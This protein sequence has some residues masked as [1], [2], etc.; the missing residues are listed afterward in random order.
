[1]GLARSY[2]HRNYTPDSTAPAG[3]PSS[4]TAV[5]RSSSS[6]LAVTTAGSSASAPAITP[7]AQLKPKAAPG[8][9][10]TKLTQEDMVQRRDAGLCYNC[11]AKYS[12]NI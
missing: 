3:R 5:H 10:F 2:E 11:P 6:S 8:N 9:C 4:H 7:N 12:G 1:M